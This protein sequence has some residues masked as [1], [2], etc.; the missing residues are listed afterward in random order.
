MLLGMTSTVVEC[1]EAIFSPSLNDEER[2]EHQENRGNCHRMGHGDQYG[3]KYRHA[4][5]RKQ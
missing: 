1:K 4:N 2:A 3:Q 5:R